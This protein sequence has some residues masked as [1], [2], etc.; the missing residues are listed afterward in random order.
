LSPRWCWTRII[1]MSIGTGEADRHLGEFA[2]AR[3]NYRKVVEY[4]PGSHHAK[5]ARKALEDPRLPMGKTPA[6]SACRGGRAAV[7]LQ[8]QIVFAEGAG[9]SAP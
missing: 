8:L 6:P 5:D 9:A 1:P 3:A 2:D 4:D 7:V